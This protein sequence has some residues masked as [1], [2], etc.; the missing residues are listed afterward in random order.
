M[1]RRLQYTKRFNGKID[2]Y[3]GNF[4]Y[5]SSVAARG[6]QAMIVADDRASQQASIQGSAVLDRTACR[7][8]RTFAQSELTLMEGPFSSAPPLLF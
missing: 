8:Q 7:R 1:L 5:G 2:T 3:A 6:G 4:F